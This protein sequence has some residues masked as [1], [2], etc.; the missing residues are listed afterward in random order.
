VTGR[1]SGVLDP[2]PDGRPAAGSTRGESTASTVADPVVVDRARLVH[3][4]D[5][6]AEWGF[7]ADP[8]LPDRPGPASLVVAL[9]PIPTL[10]HYDPEVVGFWA[11]D[12]GRGA[13]HEI[14]RRSP[15]PRALDFSWGEIRIVDRLG[16]SNEYLGF[17]GRC[18]AGLVGDAVIV[19]FTSP[20]PLL[21][22]GGHSQGWDEGADAVGAF[23]G[24]LLVTVDYVPGFEAELAAA[25]PLARYAAFLRDASARYR[26][27]R[28]LTGVESPFAA[29]V[30]AEV[31]RLTDDHP[32][33][34][35]DGG[36][37]LERV[38]ST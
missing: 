3:A 28:L 13:M 34:W 18:D 37:I 9:R 6:L 10:R 1:A 25:S 22:R 33:E 36:R 32:V 17:G 15:M 21:R 4:A 19:S 31:P 38:G 26:R 16:E 24:R 12:H 30:R 8:D 27:V 23:F 2:A 20:A 7:L 5:R 14:T 11:N 35:R 29:L